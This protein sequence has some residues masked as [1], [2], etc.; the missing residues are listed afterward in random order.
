[1]SWS[2]IVAA[3]SN[4]A[5]LPVL[6]FLGAVA[7]HIAVGIL[8]HAIRLRDFDWYQLGHFV[9]SDFAVTRGVAIFVTFVTTAGAQI[10]VV[11]VPLSALTQAE[12]AAIV[13]PPWLAL[14]AS[15][16]AATLPILRDTFYSFVQLLTGT[17]PMATV[18]RRV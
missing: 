4:P 14:V 5:V 12:L 15:C 7:L 1:M 18:R 9:E 2:M 16:G 8:L 3:G 6:I 11:K 17:R 10:I 13:V